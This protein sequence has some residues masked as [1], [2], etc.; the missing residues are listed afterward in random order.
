MSDLIIIHRTYQPA[1]EL[2]KEEVHSLDSGEF[3]LWETC[4]RQIYFSDENFL[5]SSE[6]LEGEEVYFGLDA[7][8]FLI[9]VLCGL[10]SPLVGETEVFGQFKNWWQ[11]LAENDFKRKYSSRI[12]QIYSIVKKIREEA[13][14]GLGSQSYGSLLRKKITDINSISSTDEVVIDFIGAGQLVEEMIPWV[15]K[16]WKYRIWCRDV[17]KAQATTYGIQ[18]VDVLDLKDLKT[19]SPFV[20]VAAPLEHSDLNQWIE[21]RQKQSVAVYD[22]RRDSM[23]FEPNPNINSYL[24]L[25]H[26][27]NAVEGQKIEIQKNIDHAYN[28]IGSWKQEEQ[29]RIQIR[30]FG[31]DDL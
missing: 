23:S 1:S 8:E 9:E 7:E 11:S 16:K 24:H 10:K 28:R 17:K 4:R 6:P 14:C 5:K 26:F 15:Q 27:S 29:T 25:D 12:Q 2:A 19:L 22:F 20:V 30:P 3:L 31:W 18:A 21:Q 13:L